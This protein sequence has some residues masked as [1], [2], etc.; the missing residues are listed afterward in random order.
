MND[1]MGIG[2]ANGVSEA[3][4]A[5]FKEQ[6]ANA[7]LQDAVASSCYWSLCGG[8]CTA[9]YFDVTEARGQIAGFQQNS[10][11]APG[12]LQKLCCAPG[13]T[14]G[15]CQWEGFRGVGM[16]C[17]P[18]C[19]DPDATIVAR[20]TNSYQ[21][22]D[23]G[24][25]EDLTCTGGFQ[26]YCCKGFVPSSITNSGNLLL[27]TDTSML[28][29]RDGST[30]GL[31]LYTGAHGVEKRSF[32]MPLL[33]SEL[34]VL[35]VADL[36]PSLLSASFTFGLSLAAEGAICAAATGAL[37]SGV[38]VLGWKIFDSITGWLFGGSPSKP[39]V[40]VPTTVAGR[41]SYGQWPLLDFS[42]GTTTSTC[43]C[44]V[45]YTCRYGMGWDEV[46]DNQRWAIDKLLNGKTVYQPLAAGRAPGAN[47]ALWKGQR[48]PG[49]RTAAQVKIPGKRYRCEVDEFPMGNLMESGGGSPQA[50]RLVN[51]AANGKQ[52]SDWNMWK[53]AQWKPCSAYRSG[54][55]G[56]RDNGPPATWYVNRELPRI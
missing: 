10:V 21:S 11:C 35:C 54:V 20:N 23:G 22:N 16:P 56:I 53:L 15:T 17:S 46:C 2:T 37:L 51:G 42:G 45:T 30:N 12:E 48:H 29:K 13:T 28:S 44:A 14:M 25:I 36:A 38:A 49:Y 24:Q 47:Q 4:A 19:S 41:S 6:M 50:C 18:A 40:G 5:S 7:T 52:G 3:A 39:N 33:A 1:L 9:G 8:T 26:A 31:S 27:Y 32:A 34:G 43:D 55:C